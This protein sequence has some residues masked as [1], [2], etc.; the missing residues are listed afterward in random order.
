M[1][2]SQ[3]NG[4]AHFHV[5]NKQRS[6]SKVFTLNGIIKCVIYYYS[7]FNLLIKKHAIYESL[8]HRVGSTLHVNI[9]LPNVMNHGLH[10]TIA[11]G[12]HHHKHAT[13]LIKTRH[14]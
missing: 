10:F 7:I 3:T 1:A 2:L 4:Y 14:V 12:S 8:S 11:R 9:A 6:L 5:F 13:Y